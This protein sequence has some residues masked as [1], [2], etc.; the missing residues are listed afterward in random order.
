[1]EI[2]ESS[3]FNHLEDDMDVI[4]D[5]LLP[6]TKS[7]VFEQGVKVEP[8]NFA[9]K[10]TRVDVQKLKE[11]IWTTMEQKSSEKVNL[12][13][14]GNKL[15]GACTVVGYDLSRNSQSRYFSTILLYMLTA[16]GKRARTHY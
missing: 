11:N 4:D 2:N 15:L 1:V 14:S 9:R 7:Y 16:L 13:K 10:A 5:S 3:H 8:L 6:P 12:S